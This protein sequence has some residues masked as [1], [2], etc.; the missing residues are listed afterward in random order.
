MKSIQTGNRVQMTVEQFNDWRKEV[1]TR[2]KNNFSYSDILDIG[3]AA[4]GK[5]E[6][7]TVSKYKIVQLKSSNG[8]AA[9]RYSKANKSTREYKFNRVR[10]KITPSIYEKN[11]VGI[12]A[13]LA[14][15]TISY[16]V[17]PSEKAKRVQ[18][19]NLKF[20][21]HET[22]SYKYKDYLKKIEKN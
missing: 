21:E 6:W 11:T 2:L 7:I 13:I 4:I 5:I 15:G 17:I 8:S 19:L 3:Q 22:P 1:D 9:V 16:Y 12:F 20:K 10:F 14:E 18:S